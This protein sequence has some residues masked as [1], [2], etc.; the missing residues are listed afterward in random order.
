[1]G[2]EDA[3]VEAREVYLTVKSEPRGG[4]ESGMVTKKEFGLERTTDERCGRDVVI[5][6]DVAGAED[7]VGEANVTH[8]CTTGSTIGKHSVDAD[9]AVVGSAMGDGHEF[10]FPLVVVGESEGMKR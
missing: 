4:V 1:M 7:V 8:D 10:G 3:G 2:A 5:D 6:N 9:G